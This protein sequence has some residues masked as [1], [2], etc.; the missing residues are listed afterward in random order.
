M[1]QIHIYKKRSVLLVAVQRMCTQFLTSSTWK[2]VT[3]M[4]NEKIK[5]ASVIEFVVANYLIGSGDPTCMAIE[6][7]Q[8]RMG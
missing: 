4:Y 8:S 2:L 5:H 6:L 1:E 3:V 7:I